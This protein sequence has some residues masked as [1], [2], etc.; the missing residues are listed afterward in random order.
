MR[1]SGWSGWSGWS[2]RSKLIVAGVAMQLIATALIL[3]GT[4]Q[5]L[6]RVLIDQATSQT[7][8]IVAL[9]D[10]AIAAPLAQRDYATL[11]QTL[12]LIRRDKSVR[13]LVLRDHRDKVVATSGWDEASTLP[14]RDTDV[15]DLDRADATLHLE[16]PIAIA[17]Q[18]LGHVDLGLSTD[19]LRDAKAAFLHRSLAIA[20]AAF[21]LSTALLAAIGY[22][23][24]RHLARL[25]QA[26]QQVAS[27]DLDVHV[28]VTTNDEIGKLGASFNSMA[29]ALKQR[30]A[31]LNESEARQ[32]LHLEAARE[33]QSRLT[34][35]LGSMRSG[36]V[37]VDVKGCV[38]YSN[39]AFAR[40]WNVPGAVTGR[41]LS[42]IVPLLAATIEPADVFHVQAML[43]THADEAA[44]NSDLHTLDGRII[45]QRVQAV[46]KDSNESGFIWFH[47]DVTLERQTQQRA[48]QALHDPLTKLLNRRGFYESLQAAIAHAGSER[49]RLTLLFVDLDDFKHAN[50]LGGHRVGDEI[51]VSVARTLVRL[52]RSGEIVARL[53]GDEFAVLCPGIETP[54]AGAIADRLV[55][56]VCGLNFPTATETVR[57]G[58]SVGIAAF[59]D[60]AQT[61][62]DLVACADTAMYQVKQSGK[63]G[64]AVF[65][66]DPEQSKA[67]MARRDWNAR[68]HR[69]F[70][71]QRFTLHFQAVHRASDLAVSHY[72][73][74][75]RLVDEDDPT[76]LLSPE[77]F[78]P[79]AER[80]GKIRRLDRWVIESC[81]SRLAGSGPTVRI[82]ANLS[83]RSLEDPSFPG[84]L[85]DALQYRDVDPR[86]LHIEL[87]ETS[88]ISDPIGARQMIAR[89]RS[90]GCA[91]HLDDFGSGFNSFAQLKLLEVDAIKIDGSFIR[92]VQS[93]SSNRL[94]VA[95][96]IE[97]A[98]NLGKL[99]VAEHVE[100]AA[101]LDI[102]RNLGIDLVQGFFLGRPAAQIENELA[103]RRLHVIDGS[104][105]AAGGNAD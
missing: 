97:I 48:Q 76:R 77:D 32:R 64:W 26:S 74:L 24:T 63:N 75:V 1:W 93:D 78:V 2:L 28:P 29:A 59:P 90:L 51:L 11:Q 45:V 23:I 49:S 82:A 34:T 81:I 61:E 83:A 87:T 10:Q 43:R 85:R 14:A 71:E 101:T 73:A 44:A 6:L 62:D 46:D 56:A 95:S 99:T 31:A 21:A 50:D 80:S 57:V 33:E 3:L 102:L 79:H 35:L 17:G 5:L 39:E 52:M 96:M 18:Q 88:A 105:A 7:R 104:R 40:I 13:Y 65:R 103:L 60:D 72:E 69:A 67:G 84:F 91:V 66:N 27:G 92:D 94:F 58:C 86:R 89:V 30:I 42:E 41:A 98:H 37:F 9:L 12:D 53:G 25:A 22:A 68:I 36:I 16:A 55:E 100:D 38:I 47:D 4:K 54:D 8:Q 15:I 19:G 20:A 70:Q